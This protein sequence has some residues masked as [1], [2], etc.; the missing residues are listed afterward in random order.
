MKKILLSIIFALT[1]V[2][3]LAAPAHATVSCSVPFNL[4]NGTIADATQ[5]MANYNAIIAC[6]STGAASS[7]SNSDITSL[8]GLTTPITPA[9]GGAVALCG[10][11]GFTAKNNVT[12]PNTQIDIAF[13]QAV[14]TNSSNGV[15]FGINGSVTLNFSTTGVNGLDTGVQTASTTYFLYL[16]GNGTLINSLVSLSSTAPTMP[17][18]YTYKCRVGSIRT[19]VSTQLY[20]FFQA[21]RTIS[22]TQV[23][24]GTADYTSSAVTGTCFTNFVATVF[25]GIPTTAIFANGYING[26]NSTGIGVARAAGTAGQVA[27]FSFPPTGT[28]LI[29]FFQ[30]SLTVARTIFWCNS[31]AGNL[32]VINGWQDS[33][34]VN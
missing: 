23:L 30:A 16:I 32:I 12:F 1:F 20:S 21:G 24:G 33:V 7:G 10:A 27:A 25:A 3:E 2:M 28:T 15:Q 29:M 5:V 19:N 11:T 6:L 4:T 34:N 18:G 17:G 26:V 9:Q 31:D 14:V 22:I 8:N 13:N